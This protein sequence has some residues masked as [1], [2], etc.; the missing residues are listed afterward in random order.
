MK[1]G[2]MPNQRNS[3]QNKSNYRKTQLPTNT[4][5]IENCFLFIFSNFFQLESFK[6]LQY[7]LKF[8]MIMGKYIKIIMND[9]YLTKMKI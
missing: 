6:I 7:K 5:Y 3:R 2:V 8:G 4:T 1:S 9:V